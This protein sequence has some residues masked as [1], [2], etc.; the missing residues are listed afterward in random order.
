MKMDKA[1]ISKLTFNKP[2]GQNGIA[3]HH[4][5]GV[6]FVSEEGFGEQGKSPKVGF[7]RV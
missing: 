7:L 4:A 2:S 1:N 6:E 5:Y 3:R